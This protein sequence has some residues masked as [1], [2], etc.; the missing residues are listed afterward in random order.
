MIPSS[1]QRSIWGINSRSKKR[2]TESRNCS[3]SGVKAVRREVSSMSVVL[4]H[5][6]RYRRRCGETGGGGGL[7]DAAGLGEG[8]AGGDV[9][10]GGRLGERQD[11]REAGVAAFEQRAPM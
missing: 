1:S 9:G 4:G 8:G 2:R 11:R 3:C 6:R 7:G 5:A 10:M